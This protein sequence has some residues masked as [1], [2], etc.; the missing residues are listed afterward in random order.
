[1]PQLI[2]GVCICRVLH[3]QH[4]QLLLTDPW[5]CSFRAFRSFDLPKQG[6]ALVV[7]VR[8]SHFTSLEYT[9]V[10]SPTSRAVYRQRT[11]EI[12]HIK[13]CRLH[14]AQTLR[15]HWEPCILNKVCGTNQRASKDAAVHRRCYADSASLSESGFRVHHFR[16]RLALNLCTFMHGAKN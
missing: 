7:K 3:R 5:R 14:L 13:A 6:P 2:V 9:S 8:L 15:Q 11:H 4:S 12:A 10:K 16:V 1:M